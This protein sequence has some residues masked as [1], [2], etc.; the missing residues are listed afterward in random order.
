[1]IKNEQQYRITRA[2]AEGFERALAEMQEKPLDAPEIDLLIQQAITEGM[3]SQLAELRAEIDAY[4][5][6]Q[7]KRRAI[8]EK[9]DFEEFPRALVEARVAS[10]LTQ[11]EA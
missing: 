5:A 10:G 6:R 2:Q 8:Q 1:M 3:Q 4:E 9:D 11:G 7:S